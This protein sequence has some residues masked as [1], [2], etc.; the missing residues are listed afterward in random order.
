MKHL[1][2][3]ALALGFILSFSFSNAQNANNPWAIGVGVNAVD[4]Y[5]VGEA[6]PQGDM[7]SQFFKTDEHWNIIP[8]I[9]K[10]SVAR[11]IGSGFSVK[12][13]GSL[14]KIKK[15][16]DDHANDLSYYALNLGADYSFGHLIYGDEGGWFDPFLGIG[17]GSAWVDGNSAF[18][19]NGEFGIN[20]WLS[21]QIALTV[22]TS[23][24]HTLD[25]ADAGYKHF[26]HFAG[27]KFAFGGKDSDGDGV[28]DKNDN[29]PDVPGLAEFNGCPDSDGDGIP[30]KEDDCPNKAGLAEFNGCPDSD[31][32][33]ISDNLDQCP[34]EAGSEALNGCP[35]TDGDGIADKD[36]NCPEE[37]GPAENN[38]CPWA[39]KDGDGVA[40]KDDNCPDVAGTVANN[41]CPDIPTQKVVEKLNTFSKSVNFEISSAKITATSN[42]ALKEI[43][44]V[45]KKYPTAKFHLAGFTD[46]TGSKAFNVKLS[47]KRAQSVRNF[48]VNQEGI[49]ADRLT[50]KG[51]GPA[52]PIASNK[53][54]AGREE[55][56]RVEIL[57]QKDRQQLEDK[58]K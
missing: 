54:K 48:L 19:G 35:D 14:N 12:V 52:N 8:S 56:R 42:Q 57:L 21:D 36:D 30:D 16:G 39:D 40:D 41:G 47:E 11:Y 32:D 3:L 38:G 20:F 28:Y 5:P 55:N 17:A 43:A 53:T 50:A 26:Q 51:Y 33:G 25:D 2:K 22:A 9:S 34:T 24:H 1:C 58:I 44:K 27:I 37:A 45:M 13:D 4:F 46:I 31:G 7:F 10:L 23:Y 18:T 49:A 29:C 6:A 15:Y